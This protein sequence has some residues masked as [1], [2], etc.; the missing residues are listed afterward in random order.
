MVYIGQ[1]VPSAP[2]TDRAATRYKQNEEIRRRYDTL[3][4]PSTFARDSAHIHHSLT[5]ALF[6]LYKRGCSANYNVSFS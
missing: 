3:R 2:I 5:R 1:Q 4:T 6:Y